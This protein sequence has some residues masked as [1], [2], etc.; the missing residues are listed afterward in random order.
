M[1]M[2]TLKYSFNKHS[3]DIVE[4]VYDLRRFAHF[5]VNLH[6]FNFLNLKRTLLCIL[7]FSFVSLSVSGIFLFCRQF[8]RQDL[9]ESKVNK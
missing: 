5:V 2:A 3:G 9:Q 7:G 1:A 4:E 6:D 8:I